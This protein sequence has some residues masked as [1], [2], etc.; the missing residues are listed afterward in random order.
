MTTLLFCMMLDLCYTCPS[1][2]HP[3]FTCQVAAVAWVGLPRQSTHQAGPHDGCGQATTV[4]SCHKLLSEV[5]ACSVANVMEG[6]HWCV[7]APLRNR[8]LVIRQLCVPQLRPAH[9]QL[10]LC[11]QCSQNYKMCCDKANWVAELRCTL[12][13]RP[14][15]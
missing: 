10:P 1:F 8:H 13:W 6:L 2:P 12:R 9:H 7:V 15:L 14:V 3:C 11:M 5:L 4:R